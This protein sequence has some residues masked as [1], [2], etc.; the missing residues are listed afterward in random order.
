MQGHKIVDLTACIKT[1]AYSAVIATIA[2]AVALAIATIQTCLFAPVLA[3]ARDNRRV[4]LRSADLYACAC[5][6]SLIETRSL[7]ASACDWLL[8]DDMQAKME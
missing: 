3:F 6:S 7:L 2:M 8:I 1:R 4:R 5:V